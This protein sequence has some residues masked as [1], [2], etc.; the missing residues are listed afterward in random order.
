[1]WVMVNNTIVKIIHTQSNSSKYCR[2]VKLVNIM[3]QISINSYYNEYKFKQQIINYKPTIIIFTDHTLTN[4][5]TKQRRIYYVNFF[6]YV[7]VIIILNLVLKL[8]QNIY[9]FLDFLIF[10]LQCETISGNS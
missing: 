8:I 9:V 1:M 2:I 6:S 5:L 10:I 4:D 7:N 3:Y